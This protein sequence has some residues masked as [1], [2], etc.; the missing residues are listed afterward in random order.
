MKLSALRING[1]S[2][3]ILKMLRKSAMKKRRLWEANEA[4]QLNRRVEDLEKWLER[5]ENDLSSEDH[6]KDYVS[7]EALI[8][9]QD[10]LEAEV[11]SRK[12]AVDEIV[13]KAREFQKQV[14][15]ELGFIFI[16]RFSIV[17]FDRIHSLYESYL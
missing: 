4:Y 7:V 6:G 11:K 13:T 3:L 8:K 16:W 10:D 9:K 5:V 2:S 15:G 1:T 17:L 12:D 14:S